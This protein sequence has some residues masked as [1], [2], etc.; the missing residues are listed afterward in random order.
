MLALPLPALTRPLPIQRRRLRIEI[1]DSGIGMTPETLSQLF[2]PFTQYDSGIMRRFG[3][4]GLGLAIS[5]QFTELMG[6]RIGATS[7]EGV[8]ST[9][10]FELPFQRT[11][12]VEN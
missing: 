4:T 9:F 11:D 2:Q 3:G 6:G 7:T 1:R 10:W 8:G 12:A 5:K